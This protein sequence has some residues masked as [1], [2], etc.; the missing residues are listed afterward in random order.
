MEHFPDPTWRPSYAYLPG[1]TLPH[2]EALFDDIKSAC[3]GVEYYDFLNTV[4]FKCAYGFLKDGFYWE[5]HEVFEIL[6]L[7]CPNESAEKTLI[8]ALIQIANMHL[9]RRMGRENAA[10]R[11]ERMA[12]LLWADAFRGQN[13]GIYGFRKSDVLGLMQYN[14]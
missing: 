14:A 13:G 5:S 3:N 8:Q 2:P 6:W 7:A 10:M 1:Q 12:E 4:S 9:K 11:L